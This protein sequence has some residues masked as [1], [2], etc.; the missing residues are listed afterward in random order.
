MEVD[1][2][3]TGYEK[4]RITSRKVEELGAITNYESIR[5]VKNLQDACF[6]VVGAALVLIVEDADGTK[7]FR[8]IYGGTS[9][10]YVDLPA[11]FTVQA[12]HAVGKCI[13]DS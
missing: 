10:D 4:Y 5:I 3:Y 6:P 2:K 11:D 8:V 7:G 12:G 9:D 1:V 13:R